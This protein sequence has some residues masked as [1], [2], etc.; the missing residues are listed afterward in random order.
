MIVAKGEL[1]TAVE[2]YIALCKKDVLVAPDLIGI[3]FRQED[4]LRGGGRGR[5]VRHVEHLRD[6]GALP[7][8]GEKEERFVVLDRAAEAPAELIDA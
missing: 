3:Q 6:V 4:C 7:V 8:V 2:R 1:M 5:Q